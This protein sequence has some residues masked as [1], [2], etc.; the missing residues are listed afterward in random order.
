MEKRSLYSVVAVLICASVAGAATVDHSV[1]DKILRENVRQD[2]VDYAGI[3][4]NWMQNLG[5]YLDLLAMVDVGKLPRNEQLA[6]YINLYNATMIKAIIDRYHPG[7]SP[8][9][10]DF[11][12]FTEP[13]VRVKTG[14]VSLND[15]EHKIIRPTFKEP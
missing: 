15:L 7:Y 12:V 8:A 9:D 11:A 13:I 3:K 5:N 10:D 4:A 2:R 6:F 1:F 14:A